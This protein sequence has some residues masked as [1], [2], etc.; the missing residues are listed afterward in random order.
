MCGICCYFRER[1]KLETDHLDLK[2]QHAYLESSHQVVVA[3]RDS[4][5]SEVKELL[6]AVE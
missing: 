4:L 1:D 2:K 6:N 5:N 3:E